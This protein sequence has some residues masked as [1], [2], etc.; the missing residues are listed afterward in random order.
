MRKKCT[1]CKLE[2]DIIEFGKRKDSKDG[3]RNECKECRKIFMK[4]YSLKNKNILLEYSKEYRKNNKEK[5][6]ELNKNYQLKNREE[7]LKKKKEYN[8]KNKE[9]IKQKRKEF[10]LNNKELVASRKKDYYENNKIKENK[11]KNNWAKNKLKNDKLFKLQFNIRVLIR[12]SIKNAG[13]L[14][15]NLKKNKTVLILGCDIL[16]FKLFLENKFID[17]M[18]WENYGKWHIDHIIPASY[19]KTE[20][21]VY[22]LNHYTNF[23]PLW[24][25][26]NLSKGNRYVG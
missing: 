2:K 20:D 7:L 9:T 11:R 8:N 25:F 19:A 5:I 24:A 23:Q 22:K 17:N 16:T 3:Y 21:D 18:S 26:N 10:I 1:K 4:E 12:V 15:S 14:K 6:K 13:F